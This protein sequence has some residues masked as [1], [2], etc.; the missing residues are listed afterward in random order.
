[1]S[2]PRSLGVSADASHFSVPATRG[3][4][5]R[6][7]TATVGDPRNACHGGQLGTAEHLLER[8]ADI[9]WIGWDDKTPLDLVDGT[10]QP[11]LSAW[12]RARGAKPAKELEHRP[13]SY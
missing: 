10:S 12:L 8:G 6:S 3:V 9:N 1:M 13:D 4:L 7:H 11:E 5:E 2:D